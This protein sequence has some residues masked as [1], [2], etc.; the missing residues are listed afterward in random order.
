MSIWD[1]YASTIGSTQNYGNA[2]AAAGMAGMGGMAGMTG[3]LGKL[4]GGVGGALGGWMGKKFGNDPFRQESVET[5]QNRDYS[6]NPSQVDKDL[7][8]G[9]ESG[10]YTNEAGDTV[11][12]TAENPEGFLGGYSEEGPY[13]GYS[14]ESPYGGYSEESYP[15]QMINQPGFSFQ[16]QGYQHGNFGPGEPPQQSGGFNQTYNQ[17]YGANPNSY[18]WGG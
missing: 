13:E 16:N 15:G 10:E 4:G 11:G 17:T 8:S 1:G 7:Y 2:G 6:I 9:G 12:Y 5:D 14:E 3:L 18:G